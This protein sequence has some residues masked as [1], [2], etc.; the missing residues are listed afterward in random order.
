MKYKIATLFLI[1]LSMFVSFNCRPGSSPRGDYSE[2]EPK[3]YNERPES[4][5][6][7]YYGVGVGES[8]SRRGVKNLAVSEAGREVNNQLKTSIIAELE[9][10]ITDVFSQSIG[11]REI[12]DFSE[13]L[14]DN[15]VTFTD[16]P[17]NNC[18]IKSFSDCEENGVWTAYALL[19]FDVGEW[20]K[21]KFREIAEEEFKKSSAELQKQSD[22]F[23]ER[24]NID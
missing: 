24:F 17:C 9:A 14:V 6:D 10:N 7:E 11:E 8:R 2:C 16:A 4:K 3:W 13:R 21:S 1:T 18:K 5:P 22:K 19:E 15:L 23:R 20:R 12:A